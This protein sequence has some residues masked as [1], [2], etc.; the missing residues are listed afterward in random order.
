MQQLPDG[1]ISGNVLTDAEGNYVL[2][3]DDGVEY[4]EY[5]YL[6]I[7]LD[8]FKYF[9]TAYESDDAFWLVQF[10]CTEDDYDSNKADFIKWAKT[11]SFY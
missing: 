7:G 10:F 4:Y 5:S 9:N 8:A 2:S 3:E 6:D 1:A 11:V